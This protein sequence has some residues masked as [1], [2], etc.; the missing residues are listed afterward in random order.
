MKILGRD[1]VLGWAKMMSQFP[2][3][4]HD[5]IFA[6]RVLSE[7]DVDA[8][9]LSAEGLL[10]VG[11]G[12]VV[13]PDHILTQLEVSRPVKLQLQDSRWNLGRGVQHYTKK[14]DRQTSVTSVTNSSTSCVVT[15]TR[16]QWFPCN[17]P[18]TC[19]AGPNIFS[20]CGALLLL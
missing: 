17:N 8:T 19:A 14:F 13:A 12:V 9:V 4:I 2:T 1:E 6:H 5:A 11:E 20:V 15:G 16:H 18:A 10:G 7:A 3:K